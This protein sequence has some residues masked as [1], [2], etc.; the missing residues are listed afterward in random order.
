LPND[1]VNSPLIFINLFVSANTTPHSSKKGA[2]NMSKRLKVI[3]LL[4]KAN[5]KAGRRPPSCP[6]S[7]AAAAAA[8]G[9]AGF[10]EAIH[11]YG[12]RLLDAATELLTPNKKAKFFQDHQPTRSVIFQPFNHQYYWMIRDLKQASGGRPETE[13]RDVLR[14]IGDYH[15]SGDTKNTRELRKEF[16]NTSTG[17]TGGGGLEGGTGTSAT[18]NTT[19]SNNANHGN[20]NGSHKN[21]GG[22]A[23][24]K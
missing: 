15:R 17:A 18:P 9:T 21:G 2:R 3:K 12:K 23:G 7:S 13:I 16:Q 1:I 4:S 8:G 11:Q 19:S 5:K 22:D 10:G 20:G 14:E 24:A 6:M